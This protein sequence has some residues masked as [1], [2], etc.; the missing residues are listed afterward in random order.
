MICA[1]CQ[2]N[3]ADYSNYCYNCGAPIRRHTPAEISRRTLALGEGR[4]VYLLAPLV[5]K[6]K[7]EHKDVF[8]QIR[9]GGFL[10]ARVNGV[11]TEVRDSPR[12]NPRQ[13]TR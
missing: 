1:S 6:A 10:R 4:K 13:P 12:L 7:G 9:Q 3:I 2:K 5:R 8:Q 11:L